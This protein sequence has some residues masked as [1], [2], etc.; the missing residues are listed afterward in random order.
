MLPRSNVSAMEAH[1]Y[2]YYIF[3]QDREANPPP[4]EVR[5][6][7]LAALQAAWEAQSRV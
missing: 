5:A 1:H 7:A 2:L 6:A 3:L 4:P